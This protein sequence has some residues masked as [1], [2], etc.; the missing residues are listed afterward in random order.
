MS[1]NPFAG[2]G[3][4]LWRDGAADL[5]APLSPGILAGSHPL[6][7]ADA[8]RLAPWRE[9]VLGPE[10]GPAAGGWLVAEGA[11]GQV[12][13]AVL[14]VG[15][16]ASSLDVARAFAAA[17]LLPPFSSVL[18]L[19]QTSGRGQMRRDWVSPPGNLYAALSWPADAGALGSAAPVVVGACLADGL[20]AKGFAARVKWPNDLLVDGAK[21][22]GI[23]LEER[24]GAVVAGIGINLSIAPDA[25]LL[26]REHAVPAAALDAFGEVPGAVTLWAELV[27][28]GQT[29]YLQCVAVSGAREL[30]RFLEGRLAWMGREVHVRENDADGFRAR[31]VG[32]TEDGG[33]R[34]R[35]G[36]Q[37]PG[38]DLTLHSGSIS[39]L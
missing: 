21:V 25:A 26:R 8:A 19:S 17:G 14:C 32:L 12:A 4:W 31:I 37:C 27:K 29:C 35:R 15:R 33:L 20:Y 18:A 24:G 36:D 16:C 22:G 10:H 11:A 38:Q 34:L 30:S 13:D 39:L 7:A 28:S 3:V 1:Q 2:G 5:A 23:L 6:W 9:V